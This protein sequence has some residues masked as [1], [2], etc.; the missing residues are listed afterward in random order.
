MP[1]EPHVVPLAR[2]NNKIRPVHLNPHLAVLV[3]S[4]VIRD[5]EGDLI[6]KNLTVFKAP[7]GW[8]T[9]SI[10]KMRNLHSVR[11]DRTGPEKRN[12]LT[13]VIVEYLEVKLLKVRDTLSGCRCNQNI[14]TN[15]SRSRTTSGR[16]LL[17]KG[18]S[19]NQDRQNG[20]Y[21]LVDEHRLT[22]TKNPVSNCIPDRTPCTP[23]QGVVSS[24]H[25]SAGHRAKNAIQLPIHTQ[26]LDTRDKINSAIN[27]SGASRTAPFNAALKP[28]EVQP[29]SLSFE[30]LAQ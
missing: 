6:P 27:Q 7:I 30:D 14:E 15:A 17:R 28:T 29:Q 18:C 5:V 20:K 11:T 13:Q 4:R 19:T 2:S 8:S 24:P 22:P 1:S 23:F 12:R 9:S 26:S 10:N 16:A 25:Q 3:Q 21:A